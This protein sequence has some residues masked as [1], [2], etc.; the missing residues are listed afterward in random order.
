MD[1]LPKIDL[2]VGDTVIMIH[3]KV[4]GLGT[5]IAINLVDYKNTYGRVL[6]SWDVYGL[7]THQHTSLEVVDLDKLCWW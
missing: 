4:M 5:V 1:P 7:Q 3:G 6:V 2:H